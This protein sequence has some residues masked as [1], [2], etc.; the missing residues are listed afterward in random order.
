VTSSASPLEIWAANEIET[1]RV[2]INV[3]LDRASNIDGGHHKQWI[4]DQMVRALT[5][6]G[7]EQWVIDYESC[8]Q[9]EC[10]RHHNGSDRSDDCEDGYGWDEGIAP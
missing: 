4:I 10:A 2:K 9:E 7:Y 5:G 1:Q 6:D 3:A 8:G